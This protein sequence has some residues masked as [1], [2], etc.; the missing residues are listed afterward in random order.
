MVPTP[1]TITANSARVEDIVASRSIAIRDKGSFYACNLYRIILH[2]VAPFF[3][4]NYPAVIGRIVTKNSLFR[5][6]S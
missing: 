6:Q 1:L 5:V 2:F 3:R 4:R